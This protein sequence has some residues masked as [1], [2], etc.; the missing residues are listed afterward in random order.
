MKSIGV[1]S[2]LFTFISFFTFAQNIEIESINRQENFNDNIFLKSSQLVEQKLDSA[3]RY[4]DWDENTMEWIIGTKIEFFC[5][6][7]GD[8]NQSLSY[9]WDGIDNQWIKSQKSEYEY[10]GI[11]L[12]DLITVYNWN[13]IDKNWV[14]SIK[15]EFE[16][17]IDGQDS[18]SIE[19]EYTWD[20]NSDEWVTTQKNE[21]SYNEATNKRQYL[22]YIWDDIN[23]TWT[24]S[25]QI[26]EYFYDENGN[27]ILYAIYKNDDESG[28]WNITSKVEYY[29][30][31]MQQLTEELSYSTGLIY[32]NGE[33]VVSELSLSQKHEY[34]YDENGNDTLEYRYFYNYENWELFEKINKTY[35]N[36]GKVDS[37]TAKIYH[38]ING[39][40]VNNSKV[41]CEYDTYGNLISY[42]EYDWDSNQS[43]WIN[44]GALEYYYSDFNIT[45]N[46]KIPLLLS[47]IYPNP[48]SDVLTFNFKGEYGEATLELY[49]VKGQKLKSV[50]IEN[51]E[52][53]NVS[54]LKSGLYFYILNVGGKRQSGKIIKE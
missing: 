34:N 8:V 14:S 35:D 47:K 13:D 10:N 30:D 20:D 41:L 22:I 54:E 51:N 4:S 1:L 26:R 18:L 33:F 11:N 17:S 43:E 49:D 23:L 27:A 52:I 46:E 31:E 16:I 42:D 40:W 5:N 37:E 38:S 29:Y 3:F 32:I 15:R 36:N 45:S 6:N 12:I 48:V 50:T 7:N 53:L 39:Q 2:F 28:Q 25:D 19:Y 24:I 9:S 44:Y 21:N